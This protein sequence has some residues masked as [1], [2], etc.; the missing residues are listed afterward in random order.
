MTG[1]PVPPL[2]R[3]TGAD[4][5]VVQVDDYFSCPLFDAYERA[6]ERRIGE[7]EWD[8]AGIRRTVEDGDRVL[9]V[10]CGPGRVVLD[11]LRTYGSC[12]VTG[13]DLSTVAVARA[14]GRVSEIGEAKRADFVVADMTRWDPAGRF[15][16]A[17]VADCS[18]NAFATEASLDTLLDCLASTLVPDG[19]MA[20]SIF[21]D[22]AA[23]ELAGLD[24]R[25]TVDTF[26]T[27]D[28]IGY[29]CW[30]AMAFDPTERMLKRS[31][32]VQTSV[33]AP[34]EGVLCTMVDRIWSPSEIL[35]MASRRGFE[36]HDRVP[37]SVDGGSA[38]GARTVTLVLQRTGS[39]PPSTD[40]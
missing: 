4:V 9:E 22:G 30:W 40:G 5:R 24:G 31:V 35:P 13:I 29:A 39:R 16:V 26:T 14:A 17:V 19:R 2:G 27:D 36:V 37:G 10:G 18:L 21:D 6:V 20:L 11:L 7:T 15:D 23:A 28:G 25:F 8:L 32:F 3:L 38:Q 1:D 34:S 33:G 12:E